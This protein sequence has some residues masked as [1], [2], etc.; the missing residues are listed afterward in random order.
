MSTRYGVGAAKVVASP[1]SL[2]EEGELGGRNKVIYD[3]IVLT[4][5]VT[6]GDVLVMG[7]LLPPG[8]RA[9]E[10]TLDTTD[11]DA[12]ATALA[13]VGWAASADGVEAADADGFITSF[14]LQAS[15]RAAMSEIAASLVPGKFK[16]FLSAVQPQIA[17]TGSGN[18]ASGT[19]YMTLQ[20]LID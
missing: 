6:A 1:P 5:V 15:G 16:K 13:T 17:I 14:S 2:I 18:V 9:I 4:A 11:L 8:A 12:G 20:Y 19:I 10:C 3:T 7:G